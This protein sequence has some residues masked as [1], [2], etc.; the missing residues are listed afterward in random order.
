MHPEPFGRLLD[1]ADFHDVAENEFALAAGVAGVDDG[2][3]VLAFCE[4]EDLLKADFGIGFGV[5]IKLIRDG[6]EHVELPRQFFAI[7]AHWH[8]QLD[9]VADCGSN[10]SLVVFEVNIAAGSFF[11][12]LAEDLGEDLGK[13]G[14]DAGFLGDD[15]CFSHNECE[16]LKG[17]GL[18]D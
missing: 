7:R 18:R 14:H 4:F 5:E 13:V 15:E 6:G 12:E 11:F 1:V 16:P 9:E 2:V 17:Y 3:H 10:Q 8:A